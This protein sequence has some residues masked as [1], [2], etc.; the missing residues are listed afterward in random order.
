MNIPDS[1]ARIEPQSY[2]SDNLVQ[3]VRALK[4]DRD[5]A[6]CHTDIIYVDFEYQL[7]SKQLRNCEAISSQQAKHRFLRPAFSC[8]IFRYS[9]LLTVAELCSVMIPQYIATSRSLERWTRVLEVQTSAANHRVC[10]RYPA[11]FKCC[12]SCV[13]GR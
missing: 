8:T 3:A 1:K 11:R 12:R 4:L 13:I 5:Y 2:L 10:N 6:L 9:C 7:F